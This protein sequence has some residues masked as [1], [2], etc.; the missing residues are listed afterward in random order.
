[1]VAIELGFWNDED[2]DWNP[3]SFKQPNDFGC[4]VWFSVLIPPSE[5]CGRD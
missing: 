5:G 1:M 4:R 3:G 2:L